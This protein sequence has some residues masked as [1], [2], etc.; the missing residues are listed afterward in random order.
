LYPAIFI[1]IPSSESSSNSNKPA[2]KY[3]FQIQKVLR[4]ENRTLIGSCLHSS[5]I[6]TCVFL[7]R[8]VLNKRQPPGLPLEANTE[9]IKTAIHRLAAGCK[10]ESIP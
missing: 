1:S 2:L 10:R 4:Q 9:V 3:I 8:C 7:V 6:T 5:Q